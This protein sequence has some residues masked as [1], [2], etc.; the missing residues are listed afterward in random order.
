MNKCQALL[1]RERVKVKT[2]EREVGEEEGV[3]FGLVGLVGAWG[4]AW[5]GGWVGHIYEWATFAASL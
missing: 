2:K 1:E 3:G 4:G 5:V